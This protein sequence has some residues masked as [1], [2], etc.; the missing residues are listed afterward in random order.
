VSAQDGG[1]EVGVQRSRL[2]RELRRLD[3]IF[4]LISAMVVVDT[5][6]AIAIGGAQTFT[7]LLVLFVFFFV[8]SALCSA[9]LGAAMPE[10]GGVYVW[11]RR[12][13]GRFAGGVASLL[14]W[15]GTPMWLGGSVAVVAMAVV[16]R[17]FGRLDMAGMYLFGT[18]FI[19]IATVAA[20]V[21]LRVGKWIPTSGAVSQIA[22]LTFFTAT[23]V[24]YGLDHGLHGLSAGAFVPTRH[25]FIV[26]VPILIY[27]FVGIELPTSAAEEMVDPRR[28]IPAA[29]GRAGIGQL[30]M[31]AIPILTVLLVLPPARVTSL[32]GLIDA[33]ATVFTVYGGHVDNN[34]HVVLTGVGSVIGALAGLA[35]VW[36]LLASGAAGT[37]GA[38]RAQAAACLE[39]AGPRWLGHISERTGVPVNMGLV[40]GGLSLVTMIVDLSLT[41]G[42][43]Q[44]YFS[45]ALTVAVALIM[46]AYLIIFPTFVALRI[47]EPDLERP[48]RVPGGRGTAWVITILATGW[49]FLAAVSLLWPGVLTARPD[50]A[51]PAGFAG[52]RGG[53]EMLVLA[54]IAA[55]LLLYAALYA[56]HRMPTAPSP[57]ESAPEPAGAAAL[58]TVDA[59]EH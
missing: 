41:A 14:Y 54:P 57:G 23:A 16:G 2:R 32:H 3:T 39:G 49:S 31:Y 30:L 12:C 9:E 50:T 40:T 7:W 51:L 42:N 45:A 15:A 56:S 53:F 44:R 59:P 43:G 18:A 47:S 55:L 24:V 36:V 37:M 10:E 46:L 20:V 11:V 25:T 1:G 6:G 13:F 35:F 34:G 4:F 29:I 27:S 38:G 22:L 33:M 19:A 58:L 5:I 26:V 17:F 52:D 8:P 28:D 48:F 21:P